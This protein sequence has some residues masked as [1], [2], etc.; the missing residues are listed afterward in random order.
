MY[1][2]LALISSLTHVEAGNI[3]LCNSS[4]KISPRVPSIIC[5]F[6]GVS[7][8]SLFSLQERRSCFTSLL[9]YFED[10]VYARSGYSSPQILCL[11]IGASVCE[12]L[13]SIGIH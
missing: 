6:F 10:D 4:V 1:D 2:R 9:H 5:S 13:P 8:L 7:L 12:R 3:K 11:A